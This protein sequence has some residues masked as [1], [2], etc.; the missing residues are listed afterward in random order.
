MH[1]RRTHCTYSRILREAGRKGSGPFRSP[2]RPARPHPSRPGRYEV[3]FQLPFTTLAV[4]SVLNALEAEMVT[5]YTLPLCKA[6]I[7]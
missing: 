4:A 3:H 6:Y 2:G 1:V 7:W 5:M